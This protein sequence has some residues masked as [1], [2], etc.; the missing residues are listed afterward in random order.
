MLTDFT[1]RN[2]RGIK[3]LTLPSL[4]R[5]NLFVGK[6]GVGKTSVLEAVELWAKKGDPA[7][8]RAL[9]ARRD[10]PMHWEPLFF[11]TAD[12]HEGQG[13]SDGE[14]THLLQ[15]G[16]WDASRVEP[17]VLGPEGRELRL[18]CDFH[19][20]AIGTESIDQWFEISNPTAVGSSRSQIPGGSFSFFVPAG[21]LDRAAVAAAWAR[22][23]EQRIDK[24]AVNALSV[25]YPGIEDI[26]LIDRGYKLAV[27]GFEGAEKR[28][29]LARLGDGATRIFGLSLGLASAKWGVLLVD[30][31]E[32]GLHY[33]AQVDVWRFLIEAA[34]KLD[35]Q[36]FA[37]THS[38]DAV[39]A[40]AEASSQDDHIVYRIQRHRGE[41]H[42]VPFN[43]GDLDF[44]VSEELEVR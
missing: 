30:E 4:K 43:S 29:P 36:I 1:I 40:L 9:L 23:Y 6:N 33:S 19:T 27:V 35:V 12:T 15:A 10:E 21:G 11:D 8:I 25:L 3:E 5:V 26:N 17:A 31:I 39:Y 13:R 24:D 41:L 16:S 34:T 28:V 44:A 18:G 14:A 2:F 7:A 37:T 38:R 20:L 22:F 42:A 32:N